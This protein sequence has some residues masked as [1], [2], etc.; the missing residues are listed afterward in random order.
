MTNDG[1]AGGRETNMSSPNKIAEAAKR[2]YG[3]KF[4]EE[5]ERKHKGKYVVIDIIPLDSGWFPL[6]V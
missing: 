2:I 5:Y 6:R 1:L 3:E 4:K